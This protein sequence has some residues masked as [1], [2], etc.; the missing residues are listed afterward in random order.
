MRWHWVD[1][2]EAPQPKSV[3][4]TVHPP[5]YTG[6]PTAAGERHLNVL[7]GTSIEVRGTAS[8]P[9]SAARILIESE[10]P[11]EATITADAEGNTSR[12]FHIAP[13]KWTA[14]KTGQYTLE[15]VGSDGLE[16]NVG[17]WNLRVEPDSPPSVSW[18][19]PSED[20]YVTPKAVIPIELVVKDNLAIQRVDLT[21]QRSDWSEAERERESAAAKIE[22]YRGPEKASPPIGGATSP[23]AD[24]RVVEYS[25]DLVALELPV[26]AEITLEAEAADYR[27]GVGR[28]V[29]PRRITIITPDELET[30]LADRQAQIVRQLERALAIQQPTREEVRRV[31]IQQQTTGAL[32][33]GDRNTL[34]SAELNQRRVGR[35]LVDSAEGVP[36]LIEAMLTELEINR[37]A[38]SDIQDT[39]DQLTSEL[40]THKSCRNRSQQS[41]PRKTTSSQRS[42][43]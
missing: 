14:S 16:G 21:Y 17:T 8:A 37:V 7:A 31:E 18:Q 24:N 25:W 38:K 6:L 19:Q 1:V 5:A 40:K 41:A 43:G 20:L 12:A 42:S 4:I 27:P 35:M 26:G 29:G 34:Q 3:A 9:L 2:V 32:T 28:T 22:L 10:P 33:G 23:R 39:L 13:K 15:L 11:I 30:R 36:A